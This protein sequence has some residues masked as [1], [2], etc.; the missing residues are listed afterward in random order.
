MHSQYKDTYLS[1]RWLCNGLTYHNELLR[2]VFTF[3]KVASAE[4]PFL[5][6]IAYKH[7]AFIIL[8]LLN[9]V[10]MRLC[11]AKCG[12]TVIFNPMSGKVLLNRRAA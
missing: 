3:E 9:H 2:A 11:Q 12:F 7:L 1:T 8:R 5:A 10:W 6:Y 4:N